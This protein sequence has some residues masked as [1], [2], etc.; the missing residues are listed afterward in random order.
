[1]HRDPRLRFHCELPKHSMCSPQQVRGKKWFVLTLW[2]LSASTKCSSGF[3]SWVNRS[4][5]CS[6]SL[7]CLSWPPTGK[8]EQWDPC[9]ELHPEQT[10][11]EQQGWATHTAQVL[12]NYC[13]WCLG[14]QKK[15]S[16]TPSQGCPRALARMTGKRWEN[17]GW[18][19]GSRSI[20]KSCIIMPGDK[21]Y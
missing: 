14:N 20:F 18:G 7:P 12:L 10:P 4:E 3:C 9:W 8:D 17:E 16:S 6:R 19:N 13:S 5:A 21:G 2:V 15:G 1:M 11:G